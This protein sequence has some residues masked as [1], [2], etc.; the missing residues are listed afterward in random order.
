MLRQGQV[1]MHLHCCSDYALAIIAICV[2][3]KLTDN[4]WGHNDSCQ[5]SILLPIIRKI[6]INDI[7]L[8][9]VVVP[10]SLKLNPLTI[11]EVVVP[12][13]FYPFQNFYPF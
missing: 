3:I 8:N 10:K 9:E 13:S 2:R 12:K 6:S 5:S 7:N 4:L 11:N 1:L